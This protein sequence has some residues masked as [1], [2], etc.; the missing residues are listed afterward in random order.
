MN[1]MQV[2]RQHMKDN[3]VKAKD[4]AQKLGVTDGAISQ[5]LR[6]RNPRWRTVLKLAEVLGVR[7]KVEI[8]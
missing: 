4:L 8:G 3:G 2:L 5:V 6:S 1:P 7:L